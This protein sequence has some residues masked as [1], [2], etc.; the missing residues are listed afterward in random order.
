AVDPTQCY[1][2]DDSA[3]NIDAAQQLGWTTVHLA[4]DASQSNHGDFQIDDIHDLYEILPEFWEP[5]TEVKIRRQSLGITAE[6]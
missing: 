2:V 5:K 1:L 4:D 3:Q 6:A